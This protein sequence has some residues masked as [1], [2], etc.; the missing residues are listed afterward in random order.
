MADAVGGMYSFV[1]VA[2][3]VEEAVDVSVSMPEA[4]EEAEAV[5]V[6][7]TE[8][9]DDDEGVPPFRGLERQVS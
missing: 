8:G 7:E 3:A 5:V 6:E 9:L 1:T 2:V 4:E